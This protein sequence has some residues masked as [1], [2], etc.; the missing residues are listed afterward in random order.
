VVFGGPTNVDADI[1]ATA[2]LK[3]HTP[4]TSYPTKWVTIHTAGAGDTTGFD[5]NAAAKA[6]GATPFK[7]PE[8]MA[9]LPASNFQT[10]FFDPTGDTDSVAGENP[11]LQARG[12][13]GAIFRVDLGNNLQD[14]QISL[15]FL[16]DHDHN[17]FDNLTF[18]NEHQL[19]AA[20]D[21]GDTLH[22][23]LNTL[24]SVWA[25]EVK[26]S[27]KAP[28]RFIALGR[29]ATSIT[30]GEDNEP[31]GVFVS[32]GSTDPKHM[33]GTSEHLAHARGFFTQQHGDNIV[34]EIS[35]K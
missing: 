18:A 31:T 9:W 26:A 30:H 14:G 1:S 27:N 13:Y 21:R 8:N 6:A 16:G 35:H 3:L 11:F 17:S 4:G 10:F 20:E 28:I 7:R 5:A 33:L 12:A 25:F 34:Y 19:L 2:Q 23:Q 15:F 29:D 22:T 32:N 24:D